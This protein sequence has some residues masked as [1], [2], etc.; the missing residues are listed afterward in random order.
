MEQPLIQEIR[1]GNEQSFE[2]A[3][4]MHYA[5][6]C[7]YANKL[8]KDLDEAEEIVQETFYKIWEKREQLEITIS[9]KAYVFRAVHNACLNYLKHQKV[10]KA[11]ADHV[12]A[13]HEEAANHDPAEQNELEQHVVEALDALPEKCREVFELSRFEGLKYKEIAERLEISEKTVENQMGK[14]FKILREKLAVYLKAA[15]L[16]IFFSLFH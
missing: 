7:G 8:L 10:R 2:Q 4:H 6:L 9:F 16:W 13:N 14:A 11:Y 1:E 15:M 5:V 3:F 12:E